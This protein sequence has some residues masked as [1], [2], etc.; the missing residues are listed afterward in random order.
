MCYTNRDYRREEQA[1]RER[2]EEL[3]RQRSN[4]AREAQK[5]FADRDKDRVLVKS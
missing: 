4:E 1:R 5:K 2:R 3:R